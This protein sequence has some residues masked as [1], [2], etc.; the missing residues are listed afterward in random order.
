MYTL[1][2]EPD[3]TKEE[4]MRQCQGAQKILRMMQI[5]G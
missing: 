1:C 3:R 5:E 4:I 2:G